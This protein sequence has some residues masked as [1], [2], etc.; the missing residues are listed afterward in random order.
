MSSEGAPDRESMREIESVSSRDQRSK[1]KGERVEGGADHDTGASFAGMSESEHE[2]AFER[3]EKQKRGKREGRDKRDR[4]RG[5]REREGR[6]EGKKEIERGRTRARERE[7]ERPFARNHISHK[8]DFGHRLCTVLSRAQ[9][10]SAFA[11]PRSPDLGF[12]WLGV[13]FGIWGWSPL[14]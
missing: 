12:R 6:R 4:T 7:T 1:S 13:G 8:K 2:H 3:E 14:V 11:P 9:N 5:T 10:W